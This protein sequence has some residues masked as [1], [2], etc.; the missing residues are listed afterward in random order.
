MEDR[1]YI[2]KIS[3]DIMGGDNAPEAFIEAIKLAAEDYKQHE[4]LAVGLPEALTLLPERDNIKKIAC[5]SV[6][7]MDED[8]KNLLNKKD[9]SIWMATQLVKNNEA[10][11]IISAGSTGAQMA[12][13]T[14]LL[15]RVKGI[16]RPAIG[17][18]L[19]T[20]KGESL[21]LDV[22]ANA[23]C[24]PELLLQFALMGDIYARQL[25]EIENPRIALL[26]NGTEEHK[27]NKLTQAAYALIK[28]SGLNFIGNLEGRDLL[29]GGYDVIVTDG[30]G[31]NIAIK[32]LEGAFTVL[33]TLLRQKLTQTPSRKL[34]AL[35]IKSG[36][37]EIKQTLD[38]QEQGG[39]PLLGVNG[40]SIVC[41]GSLKARGVY[42]AILMACR[43]VESGF[44]E[45]LGD[46]VANDAE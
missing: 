32:S 36:L 26:S 5:G 11:A 30:M 24:T 28:D 39:A 2:M 27:G 9:S 12:A 17:T 44:V 10:D 46:A 31:G 20:L 13:A 23:D 34:G 18:V 1:D 15:S 25:L 21:L 41:H 19:P 38:Y 29:E 42:Q 33:M 40:V 6:M 4:F 3:L 37:K 35:L 16:S 22:G 45:K 8:V 7:A 14:L 43:C